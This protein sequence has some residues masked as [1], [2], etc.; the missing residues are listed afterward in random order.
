MCH[1]LSTKHIILEVLSL[2]HSIHFHTPH[3][4]PYTDFVAR[5]LTFPATGGHGLNRNLYM[6]RKLYNN[7]PI[8]LN[9]YT[10]HV[11]LMNHKAIVVSI[12]IFF[13]NYRIPAA[14]VQ[15]QPDICLSSQRGGVTQD[16]IQMGSKTKTTHAVTELKM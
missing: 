5:H 13:L 14:L 6:G 3:Q 10:N 2:L 1:N 4:P 8:W 15:M 12:K 9:I 11:K 16:I 7:P